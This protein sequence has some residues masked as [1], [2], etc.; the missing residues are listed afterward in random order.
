MRK[1][2]ENKTREGSINHQIVSLVDTTGLKDDVLDI[3]DYIENDMRNL[4]EVTKN[5]WLSLGE[6]KPL[7]FVKAWVDAYYLYAETEPISIFGD[8]LPIKLAFSLDE[9][10]LSVEWVAFY[11]DD[12]QVAVFEREDNFEY[13]DDEML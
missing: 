5:I 6:T 10:D 3:L 8:N 9:E 11:L 7:P 12:T 1:S 2:D 13:K 4:N